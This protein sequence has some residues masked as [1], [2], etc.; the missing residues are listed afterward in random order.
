MSES[1]ANRSEI[2]RIKELLSS[3]QIDYEEAL[4]MAKPV[5]DR[6]NAKA[7][8]LAKKYKCRARKVSAQNLLN[9]ELS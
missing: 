5:V 1:E 6:V 7:V 3:Q 4:E 2:R 9:R 8:E